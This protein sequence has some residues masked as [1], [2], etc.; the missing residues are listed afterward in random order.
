MSLA[1]EVE[2]RLQA[3]HQRTGGPLALMH[4]GNARS[5]VAQ[6]ARLPCA[7]VGGPLLLYGVEAVPVFVVHVAGHDPGA[8]GDTFTHDTRTL[9]I[10]QV[11]YMRVSVCIVMTVFVCA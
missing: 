3:V 4:N 8:V 9:T 2:L 11:K 7:G 5:V 10:R 1:A 6:M